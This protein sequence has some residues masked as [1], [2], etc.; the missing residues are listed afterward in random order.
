MGDEI[1]TVLI[2]VEIFR[3]LHA[4]APFSGYA[5]VRSLFQCSVCSCTLYQSAV[6]Y[7]TH[8][9]RA[10]ITFGARACVCVCM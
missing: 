4:L 3:Q 5:E 9:L 1:R 2:Q 6:F 7:D 8:K 10:D